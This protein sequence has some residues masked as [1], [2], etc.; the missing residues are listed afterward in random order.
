MWKEEGLWE[1][2]KKEEGD[3]GI[4]HQFLS[5]EG[6]LSI[7][8]ERRR[9]PLSLACSLLLLLWLGPAAGADVRRGPAAAAQAAAQADGAAAEEEGGAAELHTRG[10]IHALASA[11][12]AERMSEEEALAL[13][14]RNDP[15]AAHSSCGQCSLDQRCGWCA[16]NS[17][18]QMGGP[19][20]PK[21]PAVCVTWSKGFCETSKCGDYSHCTACLADP[22]C[23]WCAAPT[24]DPSEAQSG[25]CM[26]GGSG[27]P[28]DAE[29]ECPD[30]W[31]HSPIRKGTAYAFAS[32]LALTHA[33]YLREVCEAADGKIPYAPAPPSAPLPAKKPPVVLDVRPRDGPVFG[34]THITLTGLWF[35]N[36]QTDQVVTLGGRPCAETLWKSQS[37]IVCVTDRAPRAEAAHDL[38]L[39]VH[40]DGMQSSPMG[41]SGGT[42][43]PEQSSQEGE[44]ETPPQPSSM[45]GDVA[46]FSYLDVEVLEIH[47]AVGKTEGG[48][49]V[50]IRGR[51]FGRHD[52]GPMVKFGDR[53]CVAVQWESPELIKC[54][55]APGWGT[56]F[57]LD[58]TIKGVNPVTIPPMFSYLPPTI[59]SVVPGLARTAGNTSVVISG[60]NFGTRDV[61]PVITIGGA[62]CIS[63]TWIT[64]SRIDCVV[65][66][67]VGTGHVV[68][69]TVDVR[70][71]EGEDV[72][73]SY[74]APV[75]ASIQPDHGPTTGGYAVLITGT[76]F[77]TGAYEP[78]LTF[79]PAQWQRDVLAFGAPKTKLH[80]DLAA[81]RAK[82]D[83]E[84]VRENRAIT[85]ANM[86]PLN[87][88]SGRAA[89]NTTRL[90]R[91][92]IPDVVS[93]DKDVRNMIM[94]AAVKASA[95]DSKDATAAIA[96]ATMAAV[97]KVNDTQ[98]IGQTIAA[99]AAA[100]VETIAG[101]GKSTKVATGQ[102]DSEQAAA[103]VL[104]KLVGGEKDDSQQ[105]RLGR[106]LEVE[107]IDEQDPNLENMPDATTATTTTNAGMAENATN[108]TLA[109]RVQ[110]VRDQDALL[111]SRSPCTPE[112]AVDYTPR[113]PR[114]L[115]I[116]I[117][118]RSCLGVT[119]VSEQL[120]RCIVP[121]G[122]GKNLSVSVVTG[123]Q[124]SMSTEG[125]DRMQRLRES[126][127]PKDVF[128]AEK[129]QYRYSAP[130]VTFM[131]P[132][133]GPAQ[134]GYVLTV[135]GRNFGT[136]DW[137]NGTV[138]M[139]VGGQPCIET[140]WLS[141]GVM[142]CLVPKGVGAKQLVE[143][144][145]GGQTYPPPGSDAPLLFSYAPPVVLDVQP[146]NGPTA[147]GFD[148]IITGRNFGRMK[149]KPQPFIGGVPCTDVRWI[150]DSVLTCKAP[151]G[152]GVD[153]SVIVW[154]G[155]QHSELENAMFKYDR[156]IVTEVTPNHCR[157]IG[158]CLVRIKGANFGH[159][160]GQHIRVEIGG[161]LC[162][163]VGR[164]DQPQWMSHTEMECVVPPGVGQDLD[165][166]VEVA[167]Q[168]SLPNAL[169]HYNNANIFGMRPNH[170][171]VGGGQPIT[172]LGQ[173]FGTSFFMD[174]EKD[175][176]RGGKPAHTI[177]VYF[178]EKISENECVDAKWIS[179]SEVRCVTPEGFGG[180]V[181]PHVVIRNEYSVDSEILDMGKVAA[182][183]RDADEAYAESEQR[184]EE[185]NQEMQVI[186]R[187][188]GDAIKEKEEQLYAH[189][190]GILY[191]FNPPEIHSVSLTHGPT[192]GGSEVIVKGLNFADDAEV[193]FSSMS[194]VSSRRTPGLE[195]S[196]AWL[197]ATVPCKKTKRK[198][199][200]ELVCTTPGGVGPGHMVHVQ[201]GGRIY[202]QQ[203]VSAIRTI[204]K[205]PPPPA[206]KRGKRSGD[207]E[208]VGASIAYSCNENHTMHGEAVL[209]CNEKG[210]WS[211]PNAPLCEPPP[212]PVPTPMYGLNASVDDVQPEEDVEPEE[213]KVVTTLQRLA[214]EKEEAEIKLHEA[215]DKDNEVKELAEES[216]KVEQKKVKASR[217]ATKRAEMIANGASDAVK[218]QMDNAAKRE[219]EE[220]RKR[221][222]AEDAEARGIEE[223]RKA[224][225][226]EIQKRAAAE[227]L[228]PEGGEGSE[229]GSPGA[230][231]VSA[232]PSAEEQAAA[233]EL[234]KDEEE[235]ESKMAS[236]AKL[237]AQTWV[238][239]R[240]EK[241]A[242]AGVETTKR[243]LEEAQAAL[244][245]GNA[246][247][248]PAAIL[249]ELTQKRDKA[250][251]AAEDAKKA[252]TKAGL[253]VTSTKE[254]FE[255]AAAD[256]QIHAARIKQAQL[257]AITAEHKAT[258]VSVAAARAQNEA[259]VAEGK[260]DLARKNSAPATEMTSLQEA[261]ADAKNAA[262]QAADAKTRADG[263]AA[264]A[265]KALEDIKKQEAGE[266]AEQLMKEAQ[267]GSAINNDADDDRTSM[268]DRVRDALKEEVTSNKNLDDEVKEAAIQALGMASDMAVAAAIVNAAPA[269]ADAVR[270]AS[271]T[272]P[273]TTRV[274]SM[275]EDSFRYRMVHP[276]YPG[277]NEWEIF[278]VRVA[279]GA[280]FMDATGAHA[281]CRSF[282]G[283]TQLVTHEIAQAGRIAGFHRCTPSWIERFGQDLPIQG[284]SE[285]KCR[286][287]SV[288]EGQCPAG[289]DKEDTEGGKVV[290]TH[291]CP[292]AS[293]VILGGNAGCPTNLAP[294][295]P[296]FMSEASGGTC[297][298]EPGTIPMHVVMAHALCTRPAKTVEST[299]VVTADAKVSASALLEMWSGIMQSRRLDLDAMRRPRRKIKCLISY[300]VSSGREAAR[301]YDLHSKK[302]RSLDPSTNYI[303]SGEMIL[304]PRFDYDPPVIN[305][306]VMSNGPAAGGTEITVTGYN[307]GPVDALTGEKISVWFDIIDGKD[308]KSWVPCRS[309]A[310][311][312][313]TTAKCV[314]PA[315]VGRNQK[316]RGT[317][318]TLTGETSQPGFA[319]DAPV[320]DRVEPNHGPPRGGYT[321]TLYGRN[322]GTVRSTWHQQDIEKIVSE[323]GKVTPAEKKSMITID[324]RDCLKTKWISDSAME[325]KVP[326]GWSKK[327]SVKVTGVARQGSK[328]KPL[329]HYDRPVVTSVTPAHAGTVVPEKWPDVLITGDNFGECG[330][331]R[332]GDEYCPD[333]KAFVNGQPC[334]NTTRVSHR[335]VKCKLPH[336]VGG[337][338]RVMVILGNLDSKENAIFSYD[339]PAITSVEPKHG[340]AVGGNL[341]T[342]KGRNFGHQAGASLCTGAAKKSCFTGKCCRDIRE[343]FVSINGIQCGKTEW[344][345]DEEMRCT[346]NA[347]PGVGRRLSVTA[348]VGEAPTT[349][350]NEM[351][352]YTIDPPFI[353]SV[354]P[355]VVPR[356]GGTLALAGTP[357]KWI[358]TAATVTIKGKNFGTTKSEI[359]AGFDDTLCSTVQWVNDATIKCTLALPV[360]DGFEDRSAWA[361]VGEQE[362]YS[363]ARAETVVEFR[364]TEVYRE[365]SRFRFNGDVSNSNPAGPHVF[366]VAEM[367][368][369]EC[370]AKCTSTKDGKCVAITRPAD[371]APTAPGKCE[372]WSRAHLKT[373]VRDTGTS[374]VSSAWISETVK[375]N[376]IGVCHAKVTIRFGPMVSAV[377]RTQTQQ[378]GGDLLT[379]TGF[380]F[381]AFGTEKAKSAVAFVDD[382]PCLSTKVL[383]DTTMECVAPPNELSVLS[384]VT[385]L[386]DPFESFKGTMNVADTQL[387]PLRWDVLSTTAKPGP[388]C[389]SHMQSPGGSLVMPATGAKVAQTAPVLMGVAAEG[390]VQ[391]SVRVGRGDT[392]GAS[393]GS[394]RDLEG[395]SLALQSSDFVDGADGGG[396]RTIKEWRLD[397][398]SP[399]FFNNQWAAL[400]APV[401]P[402]PAAAGGRT[403]RSRSG[404]TAFRWIQTGH[405]ASKA[406]IWAIDDVRIEHGGGPAPVHVEVDY[407]RSAFVPLGTDYE[408][409]RAPNSVTVTYV[410]DEMQDSANRIASVS[411]PALPVPA[412]GPKGAGW[413]G[414]FERHMY[415]TRNFASSR[416]ATMD[417]CE[418]TCDRTQH[419]NMFSW[420]YVDAAYLRDP[421]RRIT[422]DGS[423]RQ[424]G[425][426]HPDCRVSTN[427]DSA[428]GCYPQ[429]SASRGVNPLDMPSRAPVFVRRA[430]AG[431]NPALGGFLH[432]VA[433]HDVFPATGGLFGT[434]AAAAAPKSM[435]S[436]IAFAGKDKPI[437][438]ALAAPV[439]VQ[440]IVVRASVGVDEACAVKTVKVTYPDGTA[441]TVDMPD[442]APGKTDNNGRES[443]AGGVYAVAEVKPI[444][445]AFGQ[446]VV[447]SYD[448]RVTQTRG[449][450]DQDGGTLRLRA[451]EVRGQV[452]NAPAPKAQAWTD[453]RIS[454]SEYAEK[455][456][457]FAVAVR[458]N[459]FNRA[460]KIRLTVAGTTVDKVVRNNEE[461]Q[462]VSLPGVGTT[463]V[464][465]QKITFEVLSTW[466]KKS[467][468]AGQTLD[469]DFRAAQF[470]RK[471]WYLPS[472]RGADAIQYGYDA[473][474]ATA[475]FY[476][477]GNAMKKRP[478]RSQVPFPV[479]NTEIKVGLVRGHACSNHFIALSP[480]K[481]YKFSLGAE[482]RTLKFA[483]NCDS[484]YIYGH[485]KPGSSQRH[486][487]EQARMTECAF[488]AASGSQRE[489]W[490]ITITSD[491]ATFSGGSPGC[492]DLSM[493]ITDFNKAAGGQF[494]LYFGASSDQLEKRSYFDSLKV[495]VKSDGMKEVTYLAK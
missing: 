85:A 489:E 23:G 57:A 366:V 234:A 3:A 467:T 451:V 231:L 304:E 405:K 345:S 484:K 82:L 251:T 401:A 446:P 454:V 11:K 249:T 296:P 184:K 463:G 45:P 31:K 428:K 196:T 54:A 350:L 305:S 246:E 377:D 491:T 370:Q 462:L 406:L 395:V 300:N 232:K 397:S 44:G 276:G 225:E 36:E 129:D 310:W 192:R 354:A 34:G 79:Q 408:G 461:A 132:D 230:G 393:V 212:E 293:A 335:V 315:G 336:G 290:C 141:D 325:C 167:G 135:K 93:Q 14:D 259:D 465:A 138:M 99:V 244:E 179:D 420:G 74:L 263:E 195:L 47:P 217:D 330:E 268:T 160:Q 306:V 176:A 120:V 77:G 67:G 444:S 226:A 476:F 485:L 162:A 375:T 6:R 361:I 18:C 122:I 219:G 426:T 151:E 458:Q 70:T 62:P 457:F 105:K 237:L 423:G 21:P 413:T 170:G 200:N 130:V 81:A 490:K 125:T 144:T 302:G 199:K 328:P 182:L 424:T 440:K 437:R 392:C 35:G 61:V 416:T 274:Y 343:P 29:G 51:N 209:A 28:G 264:A 63:Q 83:E 479:M 442:M 173:N 121:E 190:Q 95:G 103:E 261:W 318:A 115:R 202:V 265:K 410:G 385:V 243:A 17:A 356:G 341:V 168:T 19:S 134:G 58:L 466:D 337:N 113:G 475:P 137:G 187:E 383:S 9:M 331:D 78:S 152:H 239:Q 59:E 55:T 38:A 447:Q 149:H 90:V 272:P 25:A 227:A 380:N 123:N 191:L 118:G 142:E 210:E 482:A 133:S 464:A 333:P 87:M 1:K 194:A 185:G 10:S 270:E 98:G 495:Q 203:N 269:G 174:P 42:P 216:Y 371:V 32:K 277:T 178:G 12:E 165:V 455:E 368:L 260:V 64:H 346:V 257:T 92:G 20:G 56:D 248:V 349:V 40:F 329:F 163:D 197:R 41:N 258:E 469:E 460:K 298:T 470:D 27:G 419:C 291:R 322:F 169:F 362:S 110:D 314:T 124:T 492:G 493:P 22:Y 69:A 7:P 158:E 175:D 436:D 145:V 340:P 91:A 53:E 207:W 487:V 111:A 292:K 378:D 363:P 317:L 166:Q 357:Q 429:P 303:A 205:C 282:G 177:H 281:A 449:E 100:A 319:F 439:V 24:D 254:E 26:E 415:C 253:S 445:A 218:Q 48:T 76:D 477:I 39:V 224:K 66:P 339:V 471:L 494:Y 37:V 352:R 140:T 147:G 214:G 373:C 46:K 396:W 358:T 220:M 321:V 312:S 422:R 486:Q 233:I 301:Y 432:R 326:P 456:A 418:A 376:D 381:G 136:R 146:R 50:S 159:E 473:A 71:S 215:Q 384:P 247:G 414:V 223:S 5:M 75:I 299:A 128:I 161:I 157:T 334:Q 193:V 433:T 452:L 313:D 108:N 427:P 139:T 412:S 355:Q 84:Q 284:E 348:T 468:G 86:V 112:E 399:N 106:F 382:F 359:K 390:T 278:A 275:S 400:D 398:S 15:C 88:S 344:V 131:Y 438:V 403:G 388:A 89:W 235:V 164:G 364:P 65:P 181:M 189:A 73:L 448:V 391:F 60:A 238:S 430:A 33:P 289:T 338:L 242:Q 285:E 126:A 206:I 453:D 351:V 250:A 114:C 288:E 213:I 186:Y 389:G 421:N 16:A 320:V 211:P 96:N 267:D 480:E 201:T 308:G 188:K 295:C 488:D 273:A 97:G 309:T 347:K 107:E 365:Y 407:T 143:V 280:G 255:K 148:L 316:L 13:V 372:G 204:L 431:K 387:H 156:P 409:K 2:K 30:T 342:V 417:E 102:E 478:V 208:F 286:V 271:T 49:I 459:P 283:D 183:E 245:K 155:E 369:K 4:D 307:F 379:L 394:R 52:F 229:P 252:L 297:M 172:L 80:G 367:T 119:M 171:D 8:S 360:R 117:D 332:N 241:D 240:E 262:A 404:V 222:E 104:N 324:G 198:S 266:G 153:K 228:I 374:G 411:A 386:H 472:L 154:V 441:T 435:S 180:D 425:I 109:S 236:L 256:P 116:M 287:T 402:R 279:D 323:D 72:T 221:K 101:I 150:S 127:L 483:Y 450:C 43:P 474:R 94:E 68:R 353:T 443:P 327:R 434:A 311:V 294:P 481:N